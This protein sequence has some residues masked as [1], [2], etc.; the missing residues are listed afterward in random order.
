MTDT[1]FIFTFSPI[2]S[3]I[4]QARRAADLCITEEVF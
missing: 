4:A 3:F 2:Q 1:V